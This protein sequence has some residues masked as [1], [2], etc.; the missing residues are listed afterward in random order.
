MQL[1]YCEK[2][3]VYAPSLL[4][5]CYCWRLNLEKADKPESSSNHS[6][7][8][9]MDD[10]EDIDSLLDL[11]ADLRSERPGVNLKLYC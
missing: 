6:Y 10:Y 2:R 9:K 3:Y 5:Q 1:A 11:E 4:L 7:I 8:V